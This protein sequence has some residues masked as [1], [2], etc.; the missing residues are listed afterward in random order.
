MSFK[1]MFRK[2]GID[3]GFNVFTDTRTYADDATLTLPTNSLGIAF[4][5]VT[6]SS[7]YGAVTIVKDGEVKNITGTKSTNFVVADTDVKLALFDDSGVPTV[8]NRLGSSQE[9]TVLF[10]YV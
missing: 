2:A 9:I 10:L 3:P 6:D 8:K 1:G 5:T 7:E 4:V